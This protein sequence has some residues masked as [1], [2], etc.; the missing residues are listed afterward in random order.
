MNK[1]VIIACVLGL[2]GCDKPPVKEDQ[3]NNK[4]FS[5]AT[6]FSHD[7]CTVY[8]FWDAGSRHYFVKCSNTAQ[9]ISQQ[10]CGKNCTRDENI[11]T[12]GGSQ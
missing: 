2:V 9:T 12:E 10:S 3:T 6:L 4:E 5:I 7:N 8:R 11:S 1:F